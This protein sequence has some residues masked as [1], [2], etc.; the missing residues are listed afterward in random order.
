MPTLPSP[1]VTHT[2]KYQRPRPPRTHPKT[3]AGPP[4]AVALVPMPS[5]AA[6]MTQFS[7]ES[8]ARNVFCSSSGATTSATDEGSFETLECSGMVVRLGVSLLSGTITLVTKLKPPA[9]PDS[10]FFRHNAFAGT[11]TFIVRPVRGLRSTSIRDPGSAGVDF[12]E[13]PSGN[14]C[15]TSTSTY[16]GG[17]ARSKLS[18]AVVDCGRQVQ[19]YTPVR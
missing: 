7:L 9:C 8:P 14:V 1:L 6:V 11:T 3:V 10:F 2:S 18:M 12:P 15:G 5:S 19:R 16:C 4:T 17:A 13:A